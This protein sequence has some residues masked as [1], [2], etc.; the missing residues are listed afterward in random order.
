MY[1]NYNVQWLGDKENCETILEEL[2]VDATSAIRLKKA[3]LRPA[4]AAITA[5]S[6]EACAESSSIQRSFTKVA[7]CFSRKPVRASCIFLG[8][9][10]APAGRVLDTSTTGPV[11]G[12]LVPSRYS[13]S[14]SI[15]LALL[16]CRCLY[17]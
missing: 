10:R 16:H 4:P 12:A 7:V 11:L 17:V 2:G 8:S 9:T 14:A 5:V 15:L 1:E 13:E 3:L 6:S